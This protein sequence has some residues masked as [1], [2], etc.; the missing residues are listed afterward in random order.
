ME[1]RG[2]ER[3]EVP[4]PGANPYVSND[5]GQN[6]GRTVIELRE[7]MKELNCIYEASEILMNMKDDLDEAM[8]QLVR[9]LPPAMKYSEDACAR[10]RVEGK[11]ATSDG[12]LETEWVLR[13]SLTVENR[14]GGSIEVFYRKDR[15]AEDVGPFLKEEVKLLRVI[16]ER[17][18]KYLEHYRSSAELVK[19]REQLKDLLSAD[20]SGFSNIV[21]VQKDKEEEWRMVLDILKKTNP[22]TLFRMSRKMMYHLSHTKNESLENLM[23]IIRPT[24]LTEGQIESNFPNPRADLKALDKVQMGVFEIARQRM[25]SDAIME[26]LTLW[27][28]QNKVRPLLL[29]SDTPRV[30]FKELRDVMDHFFSIPASERLL[31]PEDDRSIRT[32]LVRRFLLERPEYLTEAANQFTID[33]FKSVLGTMIGP[34]GGFGTVG[35]KASMVLLVERI[36]AREKEREPDLR[37]V[38]FARSWFLTTDTMRD[39]IHYNALDEVG[40]IKYLEPNEIRN[41]QPFLEQVFKH[42]A[43]PMEIITG[44]K[45][46]LREVRDRPMIVRSSSHLEDSYGA[47]F[48]G[49]YKSLF[50]ANNGSDEKR[51][52][53]LMDAIAEVWASTFGPN[54]IEYRRERGMLDL[55][56][57]MGVLIQEV[58]GTRVG[59]LFFPSF[60]GVALS[61]NEFRWSPRIQREDGILRLVVGL[62]TRAVD[63]VSNDYPELISPFRPELRVAKTVEDT[64]A[65]SQR[66]MDVINMDKGQLETVAVEWVLKNYG[67]DYP[68]LNRI[69]SLW[70]DGNLMTPSGLILDPEGTEMVV[71]FNGVIEKTPFIRQMRAV[72]SLLKERLR[73]PVDIEFAHDGRNLYILQCRPQSQ[74]RFTKKVQ[75]PQSVPQDRIVFTANK[76][77]TTGTV[78]NISYVVYV[79]ADGYESLRTREQMLD[80]AKVVG[81]LNLTLGKRKFILMGPGRW[82]SR[83]DIKLGVPI[84][85]RDINNTAL[86]IEVARSKGGYVPELS[87]GTHFFQDLVEANIQY[88]PLYPDDVGTMFN[89]ALLNISENHLKEYVP[90]ASDLEVV[91]RVIRVADLSGGGSLSVVMDGEAGEAIAYMVPPDHSAWRQNKVDE[92]LKELEPR[93]YGIAAIYLVGSTKEGTAGPMSDVDLIVQFE[94]SQRQKDDMMTFFLDWD[95]KLVEENRER[96]GASAEKLLDIHI[97][98]DQDIID[99]SSWAA[100]ITNLYNPA[101]RLKLKGEST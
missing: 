12:F 51:L 5:K 75:L 62:G 93:D 81:E 88:L 44:L 36:I 19:Y 23:N 53:D 52:S 34:S 60:A 17:L 40:Q 85:Y 2:P 80:V 45:E 33:D 74:S 50:I 27:L 66:Y 18:G 9:I 3:A 7:R 65:Y 96:T 69:V 29:A 59:P 68:L 82:G 48:S 32:N 6:M 15:P 39:F 46:I 84:Q 38:K 25:S 90:W 35:G 24:E 101:R 10:I 79:D 42:G 30:S 99:R 58:V 55:Q 94:G 8:V 37:E 95:R 22:S 100:H 63:R 89:E 57:N 1:D 71:T 13:E 83:G 16:S 56:E 64:M 21:E 91:V 43:L 54:P 61:N 41:E 31:S 77:V 47:A 70:R 76:Y 4:D 26:L 86:L 72:M 11:E 67:E 87:F 97:I 73:T 28:K 14:F 78:Q 92:M 20:S 49:K 98:T